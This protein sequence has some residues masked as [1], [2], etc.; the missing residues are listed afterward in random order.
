MP[1][2][3]QP[4]SA[5]AIRR[6]KDEYRTTTHLRGRVTRAGTS[7]HWWFTVTNTATD[8]VLLRT[9]AFDFA[10]AMDRCALAVTAARGA[11]AYDLDRADLK[12]SHPKKLTLHQHEVQ[13]VLT[14]AIGSQ[15]YGADRLLARLA[16]VVGT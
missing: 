2:S 8:V 10:E 16:S 15:P 13:A 14:W 6:V 4:T 3:P 5:D 7:N 1:H 9:D 11:W 12:R